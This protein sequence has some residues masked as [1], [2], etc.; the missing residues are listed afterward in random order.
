[1]TSLKKLRN[2]LGDLGDGVVDFAHLH[3]E[4]EL[5][6]HE[7][8]GIPRRFR[9]ERRTARQPRVHFDDAVLQ[10]GWVKSV[11]DVALPNDA[12]MPDDVNGRGAEHV[13]LFVAEGLRRGDDDGV[14]GVHAERVEVL[15]VAHP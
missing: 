4:A 14:A 10:G 15:H 13:V 7:G 1:M 8:E 2:C 5:G 9:S 6:R 3:A 11:L 12:Q